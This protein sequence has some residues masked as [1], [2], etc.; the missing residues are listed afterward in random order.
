MLANRS[1]SQ[2]V[3]ADQPIYSRGAQMQFL[4]L[5]GTAWLGG[6]I[7]SACV[8]RGHAVT[9]LA[10]AASGN[11]SAGATLIRS[12]RDLPGAYESV[13]HKQWDT[14][15]D[16]SRQPGQVHEAA[17]ALADRCGTFIFIS[18]SNVYASHEKPNQDEQAEVLPPLDS[19]NMP[20]MAL[21][22]QAKVACERYVRTAL[23]PNRS[24]IVR[25]GL[26][27]GPGDIFDRTGYWP[28]RFAQAQDRHRSVLV[29]DLPDLST[30]VIDVRDLSD[31]IV[32]SAECKRAGTF[33]VA[34]ATLPFTEHIRVARRVAAHQGDI[35]WAD[36]RW[37]TEQGVSP[38]M[39]KRSLPL[40]LP[41]P[42]HAGFSARDTSAAVAAGLLRRSLEDT[43]RDTLAWELLRDPTRERLAGLLDDDE[44]EL[45][46]SLAKAA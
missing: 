8:A 43:L 4:I 41:L 7:V 16:V 38:W 18:S 10:R 30:Q 5:G 15:I 25:V 46:R 40:W 13:R 39:G 11:A 32:A 45:L 31:W 28:L 33:N 2:T 35:K 37:L 24:L 19:D 22:G 12:D 17:A 6:H 14:V 3:F 29:P 27:G 9:W 1:S 44:V 34:G 20:S 23:G 36:P 21:Y 26:I 42:T